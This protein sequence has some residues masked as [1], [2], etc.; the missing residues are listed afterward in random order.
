M[1]TCLTR[2]IECG[3][4]ENGELILGIKIDKSLT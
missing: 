4:I 3:F 1:Q 2:M